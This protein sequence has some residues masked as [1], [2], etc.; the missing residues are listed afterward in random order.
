MKKILI[1]TTIIVF[2]WGIS[3]IAQP[4]PAMGCKGAGQPAGCGMKG[5]AG[6]HGMRGGPDGD[7]F[8]GCNMMD[9]AKELG[10]TDAQ[11]SKMKEINYAHRYAMIDL[12]AQL[13]KAQLQMRRQ[14]KSD[15]P[16]KGAVLQAA[17]M[18]NSVQGFIAEARINYMFE[19]KA[20]LTPEQL[21]KWQKCQAECK[22]KCGPGMMAPGACA[23]GM[24]HKCDP[25]K[26]DPAKCPKAGGD[27]GEAGCM[28]G[29]Q[30]KP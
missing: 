17:K 7:M 9:C 16:E 18:V 4:G 24:D 21:T 26:C 28:H 8:G 2:V 3:A 20:I 10:L 19:L 5:M 30:D 14:M 11:I 27:K 29:K 1:L 22:G 13:E 23:P 25:A 6:G 15:S 12:E